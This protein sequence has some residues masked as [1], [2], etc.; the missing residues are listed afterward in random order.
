MNYAFAYWNYYDDK[1]IICKNC[2]V[3]SN[4]EHCGQFL[5]SSW[6]SYHHKIKN[7]FPSFH[8]AII[9]LKNKSNFKK[10]QESL[11]THMNITPSNTDIDYDAYDFAEYFYIEPEF[12]SDINNE[13]KLNTQLTYTFQ[14]YRNSMNTLHMDIRKFKLKDETI[15]NLT[16]P[17]F[18]R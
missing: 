1:W 16:L 11:N 14:G 13:L 17:Q 5:T 18:S 8:F 2:F 9:G 10:T 12:M 4:D 6:F 15:L 3:C 7:G